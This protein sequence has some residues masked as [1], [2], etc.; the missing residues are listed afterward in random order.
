MYT[1]IY[2]A[3]GVY[4]PHTMYVRAGA[5]FSNHAASPVHNSSGMLPAYYSAAGNLGPNIIP[6]ANFYGFASNGIPIGSPSM[7]SHMHGP[8]GASGEGPAQLR[9]LFIGGLN[10]ETT[11][12][13][14]KEYYS[15]WGQV[16][17]CIVIR[18]PTTKQSRGFGFVT[19]AMISMAERA[20][21]ERP[22]TINGKVVDPKRAIPREQM[23]PMSVNNPPY[24]LEIEPPSGCKLVL[25]G[26]HWD[27]HTVDDLR[28]YFEK[29]GEVE[30]VEI[31]GQPRGHGFVVYED[32][33]SAEK[34]VSFSRMHAINNRKIEIKDCLPISVG[35]P[36]AFLSPLQQQRKSQQNSHSIG[37][38]SS[39]ASHESSNCTPDSSIHSEQEHSLDGQRMSSMSNYQPPMDQLFT[40]NTQLHDENIEDS[41]VEDRS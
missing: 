18:D 40:S 16:V 6:S 10:H 2:S 7:G 9:K 5:A 1:P 29:F 21:A 38:S 31:V 27:F 12:E 36:D 4:V 32:R 30:Q 19:Y 28:H 15:Q 33:S 3:G 20:M 14:L 39:L 37:Q 17:D 35:M 34:C 25:S 13:Q 24:F 22:H 26:I 23:L 11:D 8:M 41:L